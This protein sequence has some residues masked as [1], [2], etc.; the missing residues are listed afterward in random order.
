MTKSYNLDRYPDADY[1]PNDMGPPDIRYSYE[2][3]ERIRDLQNDWD[4]GIVNEILW[5]E[6]QETNNEI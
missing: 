4:N 5:Q 6:T 3:Q 1:T 2:M